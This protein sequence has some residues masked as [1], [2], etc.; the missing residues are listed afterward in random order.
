MLYIVYKNAVKYLLLLIL[1]RKVIPA[2][3]NEN[4]HKTQ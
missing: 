4:T 1:T 3:T 2:M